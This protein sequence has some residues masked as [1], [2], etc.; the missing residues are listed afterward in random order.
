MNRVIQIYKK[1]IVSALSAFIIFSYTPAFSAQNGK[2]EYNAVLYDY[3]SFDVQKVTHEADEIFEK[4][5]NAKTDAERLQLGQ[6]ALCKYYLLTKIDYENVY[7]FVQLARLYIDK[8]KKKFAKE[9]LSTALNLDSKNPYANYYY[10]EFY[11]KYRDY[12]RALKHYLIAYNNGYKNLY[13]LNL[14]MAIIY[15]KFGDIQKSI[16]FYSQAHKIDSSQHPEI[17]EK[18]NSLKQLNYDKSE[19]YSRNIIRE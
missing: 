16:D 1:L 5:N 2:L 15:E 17:S 14:K 3:S 12:R 4:Y 10:G 6:N 9:H 19:Y 8:D 13:D 7:P 18:L 11:F